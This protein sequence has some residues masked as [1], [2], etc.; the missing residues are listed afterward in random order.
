MGLT[1]PLPRLWEKIYISKK[2]FGTLPLFFAQCMRINQL[3]FAIFKK[4]SVLLI[5]SYIFLDRFVNKNNTNSWQ[6]GPLLIQNL[7][8]S[9]AGEVAF[10]SEISAA[11]S[12]CK[13]KT[14]KSTFL[15]TLSSKIITHPSPSI[16]LSG[17]S[18][19][20]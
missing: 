19:S 10:P 16:I 6:K 9:L 5:V 20:G 7:D 14:V 13:A 15:Q 17:R 3:L 2:K 4:I 1:P 11:T 12:Q 8:Q 18:P